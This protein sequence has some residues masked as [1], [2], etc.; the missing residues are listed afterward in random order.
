MAVADIG[1][2]VNGK[3]IE[4]LGVVLALR[5]VAEDAAL[6]WETLGVALKREGR[7]H[8]ETY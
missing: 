2:A 3:K 5:D 1:G 6:P 8:I 4:V 7:L